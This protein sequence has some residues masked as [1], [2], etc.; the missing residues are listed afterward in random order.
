MYKTKLPSP[1]VNG[2]VLSIPNLHD[3][4]YIQIGDSYVGVLS[5]GVRTN[6]TI[7]LTSNTNDTLFIIVENMG[8]LN[9]GNNLLDNKVSDR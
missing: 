2:A 5:R 1:D 9:F 6:L 4:A 3:R 7:N 8:R